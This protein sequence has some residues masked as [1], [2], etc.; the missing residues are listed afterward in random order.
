MVSRA[1]GE[2]AGE[3]RAYR[4]GSRQVEDEISLPEIVWAGSARARGAKS[5]ARRRVVGCIVRVRRW[6]ACVK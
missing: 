3:R 6:V 4:L 5:A 2:G 1:K